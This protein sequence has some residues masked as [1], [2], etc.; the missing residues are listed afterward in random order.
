MAP[1]GRAVQDGCERGCF[2]SLL[3]VRGRQL[4]EALLAVTG[5]CL[6]ASKFT[7]SL[8]TIAREKLK[9]LHKVV[10]IGSLTLP[11]LSE[12][13]SLKLKL[14]ELFPAAIVFVMPRLGGLRWI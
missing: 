13:P 4:R 8:E 9:P 14:G 10:V 1:F 11:P 3:R 7:K 5:Q 6:V 12:F 2:G